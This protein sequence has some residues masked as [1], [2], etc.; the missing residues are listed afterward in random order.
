MSIDQL[1]M[2]EDAKSSAFTYVA[3]GDG[4][5]VIEVLASALP[6]MME[7]EESLLK[8]ESDYYRSHRTEWY[9]FEGQHV[10]IHGQKHYG[11]FQTRNA[12]LEE[13]FRRFGHVPIFVEQIRRVPKCDFLQGVIP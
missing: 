1:E 7:R 2:E 10:L 3:D 6:R 8:K 4:G 13:G 9:E 12:A 11:F 5:P